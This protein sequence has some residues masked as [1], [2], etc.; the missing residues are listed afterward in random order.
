VGDQDGSHSDENLKD[1]FGRFGDDVFRTLDSVT[2]S[3]KQPDIAHFPDIESERSPSRK[4]HLD[5]FAIQRSGRQVAKEEQDRI[6][7]VGKFTSTEN[8]V[9]LLTETSEEEYLE[10]LIQLEEEGLE[11]ELQFFQQVRYDIDD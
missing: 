8:D 9:R 3:K 10:K 6:A 7:L 4:D 5:S 2:P 1:E 11:E